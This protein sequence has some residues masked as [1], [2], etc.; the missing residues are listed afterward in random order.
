MQGLIYTPLLVA[1]FPAKTQVGFLFSPALFP[2]IISNL[3]DPYT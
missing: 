1:V 3:C 2:L